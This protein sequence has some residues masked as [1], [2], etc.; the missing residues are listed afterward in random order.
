MRSSLRTL[1]LDSNGFG[2]KE[3]AADTVLLG[4]LRREQY[5]TLPTAMRRL[6]LFR[7]LKSRYDALSYVKDWRDALQASPALDV[8]VCNITNLVDLASALRRIREYDLVIVLHATAG[9]SMTL[10]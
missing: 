2:W 10:L 8:R 4:L 3:Y 6:P 5:P 1:V 7:G 9:D